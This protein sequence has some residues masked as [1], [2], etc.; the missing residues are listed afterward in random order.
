MA[1]LAIPVVGAVGAALLL[2]LGLSRAFS[3]Q[4]LIPVGEDDDVAFVLGSRIRYRRRRGTGPPILLVHGYG[5][6]IDDWQAVTDHL[7]GRDVIALDLVGYAGSDR[8]ADL[9]YDVECQHRYLIGFMDALDLEKAVLVG[10]SIGAAIVG[11]VA[12]RSPMRVLGNVL[13]AP[14][15]V[16]GALFYRWPKSLLC[17]PGI[18][19]RVGFS[20]ASSAL[21][22]RTFPI[23]LVRQ[24]LGLTGSFDAQYEH[25]LTEIDSPVMLIWSSGDPRCLPRYADVYRAHISGIDVRML[26]D[27]VGHMVPVTAPAVTAGLVAEFVDRLEVRPS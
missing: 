6:S 10:H 8:P 14:A 27:E 12:A 5:L 7:A 9:A 19:N 21:F 25:S 2:W 11:G 24:H 22:R 26:P 18:V 23:R 15:G 17:R 1:F 13:I 20:L 3:D 4:Q 16:P